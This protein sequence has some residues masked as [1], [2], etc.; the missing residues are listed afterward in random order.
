MRISIPESEFKIYVPND[1]A[2]PKVITKFTRKE[3]VVHILY[4][5]IK[6]CLTVE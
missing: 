3:I 2:R 4:I 1:D 6:S 5:V